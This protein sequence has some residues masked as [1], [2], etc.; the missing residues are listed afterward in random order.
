[1]M[2]QSTVVAVAT[3]VKPQ[4]HG[5]SSFFGRM[6]VRAHE[7]G[8][9]L[10]ICHP[11]NPGL[12]PGRDWSGYT[13]DSSGRFVE[14]MFRTPDAIY[15]N[16][17][18]H[19][20]AKGL[21]RPLR[22]TA[23]A[24]GIPLFNPLV[25]G[26]E[27]MTRWVAAQVG[28]AMRTPAT[29]RYDG[30][31]VIREMLDRYGTVYVKPTD[32]HGGNDVFCVRRGGG[33]FRVDCDRY[34]VT[35]SMHRTIPEA[36]WS[37]FAIRQFG[38]RPHIVQ[39]AIPLLQLEGGQVDFRV[40]VQRGLG[41]VWRL[42]GIVPKIAAKGGVVTNLV[43][44]GRRATFGEIAKRL[45]ILHEK[46]VARE[47]EAAAIVCSEALTRRCPTLGVIGYDL[48]VDEE[49]EIWFIEAN[50]KPARTLLFPEMRRR[51]ATA[52]AEFL[53]HL[54]RMSPAAAQSGRKEREHA[55]HGE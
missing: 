50:P 17:F 21:A 34:H 23:R 28:Y 2:T 35:S 47:L 14:G 42:V 22:Q 10:W 11:Q 32:G 37:I 6:A 18:V 15:E 9:R 1:M 24:R 52:A 38:G 7:L 30:V 5:K 49:G 43:A 29:K 19:L 41:G 44:G 12:S 54:A 16:V 40:V 51:S 3:T 8:A 46:K 26:K 20:V 55:V 53:V 45:T 48:G 27:W 33:G 36:K 39:Q 31:P 25:P 13:L 4:R